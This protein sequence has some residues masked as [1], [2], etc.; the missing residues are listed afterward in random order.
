VA[1][2]TSSNSDSSPHCSLAYV[3]ARQIHLVG[4]PEIHLGRCFG[5]LPECRAVHQT[6]VAREVPLQLS[7]AGRLNTAKSNLHPH[8]QCP[9]HRRTVDKPC[10]TGPLSGR[11]TTE[12]GLKIPIALWSVICVLMY[13][14]GSVCD[15]VQCSDVRDNDFP[16]DFHEDSFLH[17]SRKFATHGYAC[18]PYKVSTVFNAVTF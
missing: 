1:R 8:R 7:H 6:A 17:K 3:S 5:E 11:S 15:G 4:Q 18:H 13:Q 16:T 12:C 9:D 14:S 2:S 10:S